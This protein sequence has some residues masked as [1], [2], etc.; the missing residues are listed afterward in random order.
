MSRPLVSMRIRVTTCTLLAADRLPAASTVL[1]VIV[2]GP[3]FV[4]CSTAHTPESVPLSPSVPSRDRTSEVA[5]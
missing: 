2:L 4:S 1:A 5:W 3:A